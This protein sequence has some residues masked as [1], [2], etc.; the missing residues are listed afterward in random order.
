M[1]CQFTVT[2]GQ[3][4][5]HMKAPNLEND[6]HVVICRASSVTVV[7]RMDTPEGLEIVNMGNIC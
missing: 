2:P 3:A 5:L 7:V 6:V 1:A 4:R